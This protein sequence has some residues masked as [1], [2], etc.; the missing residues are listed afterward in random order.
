M[1]VRVMLG[2]GGGDQPPP[3]YAWERGLIT[4]ILQ[5]VWPD[6]HITEAMVLSP[7]EAILLFSRHSKKEG[8][9][10]HEARDVKFWSRRSIQPGW[11]VG[12]D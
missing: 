10:Y 8:L 11:E 9:P 4:D 3:P 5:E 6:D 7:G 1:Q 2:D 12:T